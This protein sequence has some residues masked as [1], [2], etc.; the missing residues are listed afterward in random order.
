GSSDLGVSSRAWRTNNSR[1]EA[2]NCGRR[3]YFAANPWQSETV[4]E[5]GRVGPEARASAAWSGT[6]ET[7]METCCAGEAACARRPPLT[8][9]RC[10]RMVL[11]SA[12]V[13]PE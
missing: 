5:S 11:I 2:G 3:L 9:E 13:A 12:M 8:A 10:L 1:A 4:V 7:R 6:S